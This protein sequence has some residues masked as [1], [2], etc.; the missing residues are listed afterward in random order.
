MGKV[1]AYTGNGRNGSWTAVKAMGSYRAAGRAAA[2]GGYIYHVG[3]SNDAD[4]PYLNS[5]LRFNPLDNEWKKMADIPCDPRS[6][7]FCPDNPGGGQPSDDPAGGGIA[8]HAV[9][10]LGGFLFA[11]GGTNGT[12]SLR[13]TERYDP[14]ADKWEFMG[15]M[16]V[17]RCYVAAAVLNNKIYAVGGSAT[18]AG[19]GG[20]GGGPG[21]LTS[22]ETYDPIKNTWMLLT[23]K[24]NVA[25][26]SL[27]VAVLGDMLYAVGGENGGNPSVSFNTVER[28]DATADKWTMIASMK[29]KR[30]FVGAGVLDG[31]LFAVGGY[32]RQK[33]WTSTVE[34]YDEKRDR[35]GL[36]IPFPL[37]RQYVTVAVL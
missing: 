12:V 14:K 9:V 10:G 26:N 17:G 27:A 8:D 2:L 31:I 35:W 7:G 18:V 28:Y 16:N 29:L 30:S 11:I 13:S 33:S 3:G 22:V 32:D 5:T 20:P 19:P 37:E 25:R 36:A 23:S 4:Y 1:A 21:A 15:S 24:M 6:P 34:M